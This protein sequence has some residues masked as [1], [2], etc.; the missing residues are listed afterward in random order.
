VAE[1]LIVRRAEPAD[2]DEWL[3]LL[4]QVAAE[5][6]WILVEPPLDLDGFRSGFLRG[7]ERTHAA[8]F[9]ATL[10]GEIVGELGITDHFGVPDLGMMVRD[11]H[12]GQGVGTALLG[13]AIGWARA[14]DA[15]KVTLRVFPHNAGGLALYRKHGFVVEGR[16]VRHYRRRSG[17]LWDAIQMARVLDETSPGSP[18]ADAL[19]P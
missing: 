1:Q 15:Y 6:R 17:E 13:A 8:R 11:G 19:E 10:H 4:Q 12:R 14:A 3:E 9:V 16:L 5:G 2:V 7:L 18:F